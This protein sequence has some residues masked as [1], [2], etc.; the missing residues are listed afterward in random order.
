MQSV[1]E[2]DGYEQFTAEEPFTTVR[3][4]RRNARRPR[5]ALP[6]PPLGAGAARR[7][8]PREDAVT[9]EMPPELESVIAAIVDSGGEA[10]GVSHDSEYWRLQVDPET[11]RLLTEHGLANLAGRSDIVVDE[12]F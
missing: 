7:R 11:A 3:P 12:L 4:R 9:A 1:Q 8:A 2:K 6:Q 5:A 10:R